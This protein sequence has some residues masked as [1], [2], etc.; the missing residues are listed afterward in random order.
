MNDVKY[1]LM[2]RK[3]NSDRSYFEIS[4]TG[5]LGDYWIDLFKNNANIYDNLSSA[6]DSSSHLYL[7]EKNGILII[8]GEDVNTDYGIGGNFKKNQQLVMDRII[9]RTNLQNQYGEENIKEILK[10]QC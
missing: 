10:R 7:K 4:F 2:E 9:K 5:V 6:A 1:S 8:Q 3:D